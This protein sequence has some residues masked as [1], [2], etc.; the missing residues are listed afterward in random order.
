M[1]AVSIFCKS[2]RGDLERAAHLVESLG[3]YNVEGLPVFISVPRADLDLFKSRIEA[4]VHWLS[5]EEII[6]ANPALDLQAYRALAPQLSQQI[7]KAEFWRL[8]PAP[9]YVCV[10]SDSR[11]IR[12]FRASDFIDANGVPYTVLHEAKAYQIFCLSHR[13]RDAASDFIATAQSM[14]EHF[15]RRGPVYNYGPFP[16]VWSAKVWQTLERHLADAGSDILQ[17]ISAR[18]H[19]SSWYGETLLKYRPIDLIPIEPLFKAYLYLEEY[20][21]DRRNGIDEECLARLYLG[22]V[23]QSNWYPKRLRPVKR[24]SYKFKRLMKS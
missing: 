23:Y 8:N 14:R 10:D 6:A 4:P 18:Q 5:D 3:L 21:D 16:V 17:A 24:L 19:E 12:D 11:F 13:L 1:S 20:E 2:Y 9:N 15:G 7:V 22:I